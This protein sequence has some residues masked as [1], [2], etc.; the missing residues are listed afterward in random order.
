M[1]QPGYDALI[2]VSFGGPEK[3]EDVMPFLENVTRG[4][5]IPRE[6]LEEVAEHYYHFGGKSPI[7]DQNQALIAA[8]RELLD[9]E[10]PHIPIYWGNR[11]WE[12]YLVDTVRQMKQDGIH[13]AAAFITSAFG[14]YSGCKQYKEDIERAISEVENPPELIPMA[15]FW[16]QPGF[17]QPMADRVREAAAA[18][19]ITPHIAFT[20]HSVPTSMAVTG[21][22]VQQLNSAC[23]EVAQM[24]AA[25]DWKLVY[26]SRSGSPTQPWLEP[27]ILDHI[28]D[29][30]TSGVRELVIAPIG[31]ISDHMEVLYD[32]DTEASELC[33]SLGMKMKRAGTV[34]THPDFVR[35]IRDTMHTVRVCAPDC[36]PR[37]QRPVSVR[38][39]TS[40]APAGS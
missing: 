39:E 17:L 31:F 16:N 28:R 18:F 22:Y 30:H 24:A 40:S 21:P 1:Q 20:A 25:P 3:P 12:P 9:R 10:G 38:P 29:L 27:D 34:G 14:S 23:Q 7:N 32:L 5:G 11:N 36:C 26:Q 6:R 8:L 37:P 2:V 35:M 33:D 19:P 15:Q 4:R 13:R